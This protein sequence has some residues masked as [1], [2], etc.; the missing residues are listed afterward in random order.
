ME[1]EDYTDLE[2]EFTTVANEPKKE[3]KKHVCKPCP[4]CKREHQ[5]WYRKYAWAIILLIFLVVMFF[6][7]FFFRRD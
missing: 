1:T 4:P 2:E 3:E 6:L 5:P 7:W